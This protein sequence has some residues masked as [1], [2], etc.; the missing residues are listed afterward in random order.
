[1]YVLYVLMTIISKTLIVKLVDNYQ[2]VR[3]LSDDPCQLH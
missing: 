3:S 1:M 2:N